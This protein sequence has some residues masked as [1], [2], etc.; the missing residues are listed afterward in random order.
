MNKINE[1]SYRLRHFLASL[2]EDPFRSLFKNC[3]CLP[4]GSSMNKFGR[5]TADLDLQF[6][7]EDLNLPN[8]DLSST[9]DKNK[10]NSFIRNEQL[11]GAFFFMS[12]R[13]PTEDRSLGLH[14]IRL[15][16][17]LIINIM[18]QFQWT[19]TVRARV[20]IIRFDFKFLNKPINCDLSMSDINKSYQ[21]TKLFW[22]YSYIDKRVPQ[23]AFVVR[24]WAKL[25]SI[26]MPIPAQYLTNYQVTMLALY[27]LLKVEPAIILPLES[28]VDIQEADSKNEKT[29][30]SEDISSRLYIK[31]HLDIRF[32]ITNTMSLQKLLELF[33]EFYS[34]F[35]FRVNLALSA[36]PKNENQLEKKCLFIENPFKPNKNVASNVSIKELE[37]FQEMCRKSLEIIKN[38]KTSTNNSFDLINF[39]DVVKNQLSRYKLKNTN[40][41]QNNI[42]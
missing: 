31:S 27:F 34:N 37:R 6:S 13:K 19:A 3:I 9:V 12:K 15:V 5:K 1:I 4:F 36:K 18:P 41:K 20:P 39:F 40:E 24:H 7:F 8:V 2:I 42:A 16:E 10:E 14:Y 29:E 25:C 38:Q 23:I 21:M 26:T 22:T 11:K 30:E 17:Y 32:K 28:I 33:F 35:E